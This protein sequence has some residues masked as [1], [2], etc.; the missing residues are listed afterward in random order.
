MIEVLVSVLLVSFGLLGA[1]A[2]YG[3]AVEFSTDTERR[4]MAAMLAGELLEI[5]RS[6]LARILDAKGNPKDDLGGYA[7]AA[8]VEIVPSTAAHCGDV[9]PAAVD[10]RM[11]CWAERAQSVMPEI[12]KD[13]IQQYFVVSTASKVCRVWR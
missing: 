1:A 5:M 6:D 2:M 13:F 7:K 10:A 11:A 8:G 12:T 9:L 4:Q 3:R